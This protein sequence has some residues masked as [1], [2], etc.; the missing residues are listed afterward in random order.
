MRTLEIIGYKRANLGKTESKKLRE[1][2]YAPCVLY[3]GKEQVAFYSPMILFRD[4]IYTPEPAFVKLNVEGD[5]YTCIVQDAQFHPVNEM[6]IHVDFLEL[7]DERQITMNIP[8]KFVG[9]SIGAQKGGKVVP[10]L[11]ALK[12]KA[13][14]KEMPSA[15]EVD[16]TALDLGKSIKIKELG[17][18]NYTILNAVSNPI[19]SVEI[20]R[21]LKSQMVEAAKEAKKK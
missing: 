21:A 11:R 13:L 4:L 19:V 18:Q 3:G 15:I 14:P 6:I 5:E 7:N 17:E 12:V 20:P 10:R 2:G 9:N 1:Q 8:V 16:I